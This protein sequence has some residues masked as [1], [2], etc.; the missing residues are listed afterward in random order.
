MQRNSL[1]EKD[2][3]FAKRFSDFV[4][5]EMCSAKETG[6]A[7]A[8]DHR[9]LVNEKAKVVFAFLAQLADDYRNGHYDERDAWAC[10]L[11]SEAIDRLAE[12]RLY[13]K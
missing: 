2:K 8:D 5:G 11:A 1:T 9:Y 13:F 7:L 12:K 6:R 10:R 4:N 3:A